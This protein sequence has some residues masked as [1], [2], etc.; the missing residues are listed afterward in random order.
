V[1]INEITKD[2][3]RKYSGGINLGKVAEDEDE[4]I[5]LRPAKCFYTP[6]SSGRRTTILGGNDADPLPSRPSV[7]MSEYPPERLAKMFDV[8]VE[9][10]WTFT[11]FLL[12]VG[13]PRDLN[14]HKDVLMFREAKRAYLD[15]KQAAYR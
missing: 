12:A 4:V 3:S 2:L 13:L 7:R 11:D 9:R 1:D 6:P 14:E 8:R 15:R 10:S 5:G